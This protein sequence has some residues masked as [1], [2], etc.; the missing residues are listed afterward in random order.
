MRCLL[1]LLFGVGDVRSGR[2]GAFVTLNAD[3]APCALLVEYASEGLAVVK[4]QHADI[5][6]ENLKEVMSGI[7]N[8]FTGSDGWL[9]S[10]ANA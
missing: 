3:L 6:I 8:F 10:I 1:T 2:S 4:F 5:D 9:D 7:T